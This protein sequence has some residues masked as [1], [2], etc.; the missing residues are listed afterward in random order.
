MP[1]EIRLGKELYSIVHSDGR[2]EPYFAENQSSLDGVTQNIL[3]KL[4][5]AAAFV[6]V[7]HPRGDVH[8]PDSSAAGGM[9]QFHRASVWIEQEIAVLAAQSQAQGRN[10]PVQ[11]YSKR[12]VV[13]EGLR[14]Y[15]MTNPV[16]FNHEAE[17][18]EHFR[19]LLPTW[20]LSVRAK[21]VCILPVI[22]RVV[23]DRDP[24][25]FTLRLA[26]RN[27]G[28]ERATDGRLGITFPLKFIRHSHIAAEKRRTNSHIEFEMSRDWFAGQ[29]LFDQLYPGD[30][31]RVLHE[32]WY[33]VDDGRVPTL[34]DALEI[35]IRSG[36]APAFFGRVPVETLQ[37][38]PIGVQHMVLP[39][40]GKVSPITPLAGA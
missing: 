15:V 39:V 28:D 5:N 2:Y 6:A 8:V 4:T 24:T 32:L 34:A 3:F 10:I 21:G 36:N 23:D 9:R 11:V 31:T 35:E 40:V 29:K 18:I 13:R 22:T 14:S 27:V 25:F 33:W 1:E 26:L 16:E 20:A 19:T 17:V 38:L 12:G 7:L 37:A 30:T